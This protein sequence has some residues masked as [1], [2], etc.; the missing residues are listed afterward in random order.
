MR[1]FFIYLVILK[2][3][4][5]LEPIPIVNTSEYGPSSNEPSTSKSGK[6]LKMKSFLWSWWADS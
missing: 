6:K 1:L 3:E 4:V 5:K 2:T